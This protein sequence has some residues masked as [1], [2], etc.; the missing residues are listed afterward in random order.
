MKMGLAHGRW[1]ALKIIPRRGAI[2][3]DG[4]CVFER[5]GR[6]EENKLFQG[7]SAAGHYCAGDRG[8]AAHVCDRDVLRAERIDDPTLEIN[9]RVVATKFT[10]QIGEPERGDVVVFKYPV[11]EEQGIETVIYVKRCIGLPGET[12]EIKNNTVFIDG[13]PA[14]GGLSQHRH[15]HAGFWDR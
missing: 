14:G 9:D 13:T 1:S 8:R 12:L 6:E 10:Y 15:E 4:G 11:N 7:L 2:E 3:K 5:T